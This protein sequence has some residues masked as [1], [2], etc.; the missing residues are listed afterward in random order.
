[1]KR[2]ARQA[3]LYA[4]LYL[5]I[6]VDVLGDMAHLRAS[7]GFTYLAVGDRESAWAQY[8][9]LKDWAAKA[10]DKNTK[11]FHRDWADGLLEELDEPAQ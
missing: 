4:C 9:L 7:L 11:R 8:R 1:V 5:A 3:C 10:Q 6:E 2:V